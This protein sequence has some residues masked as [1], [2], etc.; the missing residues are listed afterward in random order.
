MDK[1][2]KRSK[3]MDRLIKYFLHPKPE[4]IKKFSEVLKEE[5]DRIKDRRIKMEINPGDPAKDTVGL[6]LSG[7]GV[8]S[9]TFNLGLL[10]AL[11]K[12]DFLKYIDYLSTVSGGG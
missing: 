11:E 9:A 4:V 8:R 5:H 6:A 1:T 3:S 7:G 10:Q 12:H 2:R